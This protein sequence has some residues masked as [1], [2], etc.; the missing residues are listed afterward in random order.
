MHARELR[1]SSGDI[2]GT[3]ESLWCFLS[4]VPGQLVLVLRQEGG[5]VKSTEPGRFG[6]SP[7]MY[8]SGELAWLN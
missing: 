4:K 1:L 3:G 8:N 7:H 5:L 6:R 2:A